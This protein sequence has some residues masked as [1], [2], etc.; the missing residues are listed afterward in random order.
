MKYQFDLLP[1]E[2]KCLPRDFIG[3]ILATLAIVIGV[4]SSVSLYHKNTREMVAEQKKVDTAQKEL[5]DLYRQAG[6]L[7][8][9]VDRL[10][11]LKASVEFIN[12]NLQT[13]GTSF[14]DFLYSLEATVPEQVFVRDLNPK[15]F[16]TPGVGYTIEGE[17]ASI[18]DILDFISR[19]Q[20]AQTKK[21][22]PK[23]VD[24]SLKQSTTRMTTNGIITNFTLTFNYA[25]SQ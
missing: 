23:F 7:Q 17:A 21:Q 5:E 8:A 10:N 20:K 25:G 19:L 2:Y 18:Y 4:S 3:I 13:P 11:S 22:T 24:V 15:E 6:E 16:T 1:I 14:V 9:P 12:N